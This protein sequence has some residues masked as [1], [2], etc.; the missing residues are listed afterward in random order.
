MRFIYSAFY[1]ALALFLL[2]APVQAGEILLTEEDLVPTPGDVLV[3]SRLQLPEPRDDVPIIGPTNRQAGARLVRILS[4]Q[5][6]INGFRG[7]LYDNRD[8]GQSLLDPELYP[9]L[10]HLKYDLDTSADDLDFGLAGKIVFPAVVLGNASTLDENIRPPRSLPRIAMT[11]MS[12][13]MK[14]AAL[15]TNNHIYVYPAYRDHGAED[16]FPI[17]WPYMI[18]SEGGVGSEQ[19]FINAMALTLAALPRDTFAFL[20][21]KGLIAPTVQM[22]LRRNLATVSSREDYLTGLAHPAAFDGRLIRSDRMVAQASK[23]RPEDIPPTVHLQVV[24]EDFSDTAGLAGLNE[25]VMDTRAAIGRVWR[26]FAW[27]REMVVSAK[28]TTDPNDR[29]LTFEWKLLR[30]DPGR[31]SIE[32]QGPDASSARIR[33]AWH[34]VWHEPI[35]GNRKNQ[36]RGM[37]RVDIGV[38]ANNG[39][40][41]SAPS[42]ISI[43]FPEHQIRQYDRGTD[44]AMRLASVD[45]DAEARKA[46]LD[47]LLY[48]TAPWKDTAR[49]D[50]NNNLTGWDRQFAVGTTDFVPHDPPGQSWR[51]EIDTSE[52]SAA[53]TMVAAK[54]APAVESVA[55]SAEFAPAAI[56]ESEIVLTLKSVG[57]VRS[58][59]R[60]DN[61][62][63]NDLAAPVVVD[64]ELYIV[65]KSAGAVH[66][67]D[68]TVS[69]G[70]SAEVFNV[71][72][73]PPDD[74][75]FDYVRAILNV[76]DGPGESVYMV[77]TTDDLPVGV[78]PEPLPNVDA[79]QKRRTRYQI[80]YKYEFNP[81]DGTDGE[82]A[83][84]LL[85]AFEQMIAG[86]RGGG[87]LTLPNG[88]LLL[89][90]G[91]NL[92]S[93]RD[94]LTFAQ[95]DGFTLSKL[96]IID[97][98]TGA[99]KIAAKGVREVQDIVFTD[100]AKTKIAFAEMGAKV[101]D[102]INVIALA[103]LL[104]DR[105][106]ENFGWGR[107]S[108]DASDGIGVDGTAREG[109]FYINGGHTEKAGTDPVAIGQ[110]P[111]GEAG[112]VQPYAQMRPQG[113]EAFGLSGPV[114]SDTHFKKI[115][116]L[117]GDLVSGDLLATLRDDPAE[118]KTVY[119]LNLKDPSG[120]PV[121]LLEEANEIGLNRVDVRFFTFPDG[122]P[123]LLTEQTGEIYRLS[124][125][126]D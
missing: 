87:V 105:E 94:G 56:E 81:F 20:K 114:Y 98:D 50:E 91:D 124:E 96:L 42:I 92:G 41:D 86:H 22:I 61:R 125:V 9:S 84:V 113:A 23:M 75:S 54:D 102:E 110:A 6:S 66:K 18:A 69:G 67:F 97:Q 118:I 99:I 16:R 60:A 76:A 68:E 107:V 13:H 62:S 43:D 29:P 89:A 109:M 11:D 112:F 93:N 64:G 85:A 80:I 35:A 111:L 46:F 15:Y 74:L 28:D 126:T 26:S 108:G 90:R 122:Q 32:P 27:E 104:S 100:R 1:S 70:A 47:P 37:S 36:T 19:P 65:D 88:D 78:V 30:G 4:G 40:Y 79:Y 44:G 72:S 48:W 71:F 77:F 7:V 38:F 21:E 49:Y 25:R 73:D 3:A 55:P 117:F 82:P 53:L 119:R 2:L 101:A 115:E 51:Y 58:I 34:D 83:P 24:E 17:N 14:S 59:A 10:T 121:D 52:N 116:A 8:R 45:Y 106:I 103:D 57:N 95:D 63:R 39:N 12:W 5:N 33:V 123:G 120:S 31:V